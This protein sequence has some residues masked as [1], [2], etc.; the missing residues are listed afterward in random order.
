[1]VC[2]RLMSCAISSS[3]AERLDRLKEH[4]PGELNGR[5]VAIIS[6]MSYGRDF[7]YTSQLCLMLSFQSSD[8]GGC[9][10]TVKGGFCV[11][12]ICIRVF[13]TVSGSHHF[14]LLTRA[15]R[16]AIFRTII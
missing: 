13:Q 7:P 12:S 15:P 1:M 11:R 5:I 9:I 3:L 8:L 14:R 10:C 2:R 6:L 16:S 4:L